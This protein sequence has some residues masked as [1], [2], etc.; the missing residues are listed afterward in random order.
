[1]KDY[2]PL[3]N[4]TEAMFTSGEGDVTNCT[5]DIFWNT[6]VKVTDLNTSSGT[7]RVDNCKDLVSLYDSLSS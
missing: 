6:K 4:K 5:F 2:R 7:I 1:M 3:V